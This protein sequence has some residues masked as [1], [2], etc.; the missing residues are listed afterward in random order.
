MTQTN[1]DAGVHVKEVREQVHLIHEA[2]A[3]KV[4]SGFENVYRCGNEWA[5]PS[6]LARRQIRQFC[7]QNNV[8][9]VIVEADK[10]SGRFLMPTSELMV[11]ISRIF[12]I[13][14]KA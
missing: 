2:M 1:D 14:A 5:C 12:L 9:P 6:N 7:D 13:R 3:S 11:D 4:R 10:R 8:P